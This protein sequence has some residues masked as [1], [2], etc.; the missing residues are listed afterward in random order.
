LI[1]HPHP[2]IVATGT[3]RPPP[4]APLR[5]TECRHPV[6]RQEGC[7]V[8][9]RNIFRKTCPSCATQVPIDSG[10]CSCGH[11]F[12]APVEPG[13]SVGEDAGED[14]ELF[15]AYLSARIEQA[16]SSLETERAILAADPKNFDK[17]Y[18]VMRALHDVQA[19]RAQL[20]AHG[21]S[22][23][24]AAPPSADV[25]QTGPA[26][27]SAEPSEAFRTAQAAKAARIMQQFEGTETKECPN[28]RQTLP[29]NTALCLCGYAFGQGA[30][31]PAPFAT[32]N[33]EDSSSS[34]PP[35]RSR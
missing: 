22:A 20:S 35:N 11:V 13:V 31:T 5:Y 3:G 29:V 27:L 7:P 17:A 12:V 28:C 2:L 19:L 8:S 18:R 6:L 4:G 34:P 33:S 15:R 10:T 26:T 21:G 16:V 9:N 1:G 30:S 24:A 23:P 32:Q 14:E 25:A